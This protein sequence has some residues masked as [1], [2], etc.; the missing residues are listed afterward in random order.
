MLQELR[1][2][3]D[4]STLL[5]QADDHSS[6]LPDSAYVSTKVFRHQAALLRHVLRSF[7]L[8]CARGKLLCSGSD[9]LRRASCRGSV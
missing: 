8:L 9:L 4:M 3:L 2:R 5:L 7:E 6:V 1:L